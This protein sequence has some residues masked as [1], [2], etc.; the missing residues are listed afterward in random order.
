MSALANMMTACAVASVGVL[1]GTP[2]AAERQVG[3]M[4]GVTILLPDDFVC[5]P[6]VSVNLRAAADPP[7]ADQALMAR[8]AGQ[9]ANLMAFDCPEAESVKMVGEVGGR[10]VYEAITGRRGDWSVITQMAPDPAVPGAPPPAPT[11]PEEEASGAG[12]FLPRLPAPNDPPPASGNDRAAMPAAPGHP[13]QKAE[14]AGG[15]AEDAPAARLDRRAGS[16]PSGADDL[17]SAEDFDASGLS[18]GARL[19]LLF[20]G[21]FDALDLEDPFFLRV[22][23]LKLN[24]YFGRSYNFFDEACAGFYD[25]DLAPGFMEGVMSDLMGA[26]EQA[27]LQVLGMIGTLAQDPAALMRRATLVEAEQKAGETDG[28]RLARDLSCSSPAFKRLYQNLAAYIEGAPPA[29]ASGWPGVRLACARFAG[30]AGAG[31]PDAWARCG[32]IADEMKAAGAPREAA[33][34][35]RSHYDHG[36]NFGRIV[37]AYPDLRKR[38]GACLLQ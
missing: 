6:A 21:D 8:I 9:L 11:A 14:A 15:T 18:R 4:D 2:P 24:A 35:L 3:A 27:G 38:I 28:V 26:P 37:E 25:P 36:G 30:D 7:F 31:S 29:C 13:W 1:V 19:A 32:C 10:L 12:E 23:L 34:W 17:C 22:Y 5:S 33:D 20:D 16:A